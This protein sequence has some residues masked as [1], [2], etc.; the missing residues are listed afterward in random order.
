MIGNSTAV[1]VLLIYGFYPEMASR[2]DN[3]TPP[4]VLTQTQRNIELKEKAFASV[5]FNE[6]VLI[7]GVELWMDDR[8][9]LE[10]YSWCVQRG[11][12]NVDYLQCP[13]SCDDQQPGE[14]NITFYQQVKGH[15]LWAMYRD[16]ADGQLV[17]KWVRGHSPP[18]QKRWANYDRKNNTKQQQ[19]NN[20]N[21]NR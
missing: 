14:L 3:L 9:L 20:S 8:Q 18:G 10:E 7:R 6:V 13:V 4:A 17:V 19:N 1:M 21:N 2:V 5:V 12:P 16:E 15:W 11:G